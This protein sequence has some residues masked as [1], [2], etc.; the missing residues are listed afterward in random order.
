MNNKTKRLL[1]SWIVQVMYML[2]ARAEIFSK[3]ERDEL[4]QKTADL[5]E[6]IKNDGNQIRQIVK[7]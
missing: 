6:A 7:K 3:A 1:I 5:Q 2:C 4:S